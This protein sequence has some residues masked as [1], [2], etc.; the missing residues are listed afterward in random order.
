M[1]ESW[2]ALARRLRN[3]GRPILVAAQRDS[4]AGRWLG[5]YGTSAG[6]SWL[7]P[8]A[9]PTRGAG[10]AATERRLNTASLGRIRACSPARI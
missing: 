8:N 9:I 5:G 4:D 7:P 1:A 3:V 10:S 2:L 6:Q